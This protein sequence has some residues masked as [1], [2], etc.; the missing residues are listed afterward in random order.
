MST[1]PAYIQYHAI[2]KH[3]ASD[4]DFFKI[5]MVFLHH[6]LDDHFI[7][8]SGPAYIA[9]LKAVGKKF[10]QLEK[11]KYS[12]DTDL[13]DYI[14]VLEWQTENLVDGHGELLA[15]KQKQKQMEHSMFHLTSTYRKLK[16][17]LFSLVISLIQD[18]KR[19]GLP[20]A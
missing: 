7:L 15:I 8:L 14:K 6:L 3:W 19:Q 5:E 18:R 13:T 12:A 17:E 10:L 11:D 20:K 9:D 2:A 4:I 1:S 16:Q